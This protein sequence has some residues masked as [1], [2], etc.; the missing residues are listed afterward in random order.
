MRIL[1]FGAGVLGSYY[2]TKLYQAGMDVT[3]LARGEKYQNIKEQGIV[4][5]D[6][7]S[8]EKII[9]P[10]KVIEKPEPNG[11]DLVMIFVQMIQVESVIPILSEIKSAKSFLFPVEH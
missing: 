5:E 4:L 2:A 9:V 6:Y 11:Y 10:I 7:F 3:I 1:V 8:H